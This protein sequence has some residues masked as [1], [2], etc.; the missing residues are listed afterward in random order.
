MLFDALCEKGE[1]KKY[2][3]VDDFSKDKNGSPDGTQFG[4]HIDIAAV[5]GRRWLIVFGVLKCRVDN[6]ST[7]ARKTIVGFRIDE[8]LR[9][10]GRRYKRVVEIAGNWHGDYG[11]EDEDARRSGDARRQEVL[12]QAQI[13]KRKSKATGNTSNDGQQQQATVP[14]ETTANETDGTGNDSANMVIAK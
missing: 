4:V 7:N 8:L 12:R 9:I 3:V 5:P 11:F 10:L 6:F 13:L 1:D 14:T 2:R